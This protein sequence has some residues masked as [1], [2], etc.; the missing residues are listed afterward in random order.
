MATS[1]RS[2]VARP[3]RHLTPESRATTAFGRPSA[4]SR[5]EHREF[6]QQSASRQNYRIKLT[7]RPVTALAQGR[8]RRATVCDRQAERYAGRP[9][10]A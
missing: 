3:S 10:T 5:R 7:V 4:H 9:G 2:E 6:A 1:S 8:G